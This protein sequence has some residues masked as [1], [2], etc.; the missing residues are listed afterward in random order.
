MPETTVHKILNKKYLGSYPPG[1]YTYGLTVFRKID[2]DIKCFLTVIATNIA[3]KC[4]PIGNSAQY[5]YYVFSPVSICSPIIDKVSD[6][7]LK[8][9]ILIKVKFFLVIYL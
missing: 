2:P 9:S 7:G 5:L 1:C 8:D 3:A 6:F 4:Q